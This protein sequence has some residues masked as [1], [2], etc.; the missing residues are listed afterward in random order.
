MRNGGKTIEITGPN[1]VKLPLSEHIYEVI[2]LIKPTH[3]KEECTFL[4]G[5]L[6]ATRRGHYNDKLVNLSFWLTNHH[7]YAVYK[8]EVWPV[9]KATYYRVSGR[10]NINEVTLEEAI[11]AVKK[12]KGYIE[13]FELMNKIFA[14]GLEEP[15]PSIPYEVNQ[16]G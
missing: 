16:D 15:D 13:D 3:D 7:I 5:P 9:E 8:T 14:I 6:W 2:S 1:S 4:E 10:G 12:R 11:D